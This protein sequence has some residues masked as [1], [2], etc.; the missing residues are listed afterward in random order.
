MTS[1]IPLWV[2]RLSQA[3]GVDLKAVAILVTVIILAAVYVI[4]QTDR[5]YDGF[6][7]VKEQAGKKT[8]D[9]KRVWVKSAKSLVYDTLAK[10]R[11]GAYA[12]Q[13]KD[14]Q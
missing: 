13:K 14:I 7:M 2:P 12:V 9:A 10:V 3:D 4:G 1:S 5:P 8:Q 11:L 6:P